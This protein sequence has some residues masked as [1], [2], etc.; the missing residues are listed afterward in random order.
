MKII[1][2]V[3]G[4][5]LIAGGVFCM[6]YPAATFATLGWLVGILLLLSGVNAIAGYIKNRKSKANSIWDF[7]F[8]LLTTAF[9]IFV[10]FS[11]LMRAITDITLV[12]MFAVW[13]LIGGVVRIVDAMRLMRLKNT[14]WIWMVLLGILMLVLGVYGFIHPMVN[15]VAIGWIMG[16]FVIFQGFNLVGIGLASDKKAAEA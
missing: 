4:F 6:L 14:A 8:G 3:L 5:V 7:L 9:G 2:I 13:M 1:T 16:I 12:Y 10:L 15:A 11:P